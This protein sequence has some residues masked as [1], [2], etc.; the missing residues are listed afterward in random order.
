MAR[1]AA[2]LKACPD[3]NSSF[4][5]DSSCGRHN[6]CRAEARRYKNNAALP[7]RGPNQ[8]RSTPMSFS[9][10]FLACLAG[11]SVLA[12]VAVGGGS[13]VLIGEKATTQGRDGIKVREG[14][15]LIFNARTEEN[16]TPPGFG[17]DI[18]PP[19]L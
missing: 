7:F 3:E 10:F 12:A 11:A 8:L 5:T 9:H 17:E 13:T 2:R 1:L 18:L 6:P 15:M 16:R 14:T 19:R 4:H